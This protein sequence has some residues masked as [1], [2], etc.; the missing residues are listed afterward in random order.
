M[1]TV[2][3]IP[4]KDRY[5]ITSNRDEKMLR[6]PA[7]APQPY[8]INGNTLVYPKDADAGGT[9]IAMNENGNAAVLL[10]G[11]F[12]KHVSLSTYKLSRGLVFADIIS[13]AMPVRFF[14]H[15]ELVQIEPFTIIILEQNSL[16]ECRWDGSKKHCRQLP[17]YRSY[18]WSSVT[19][20]DD[21][22]I[23]KREQ[24]FAKWLNTH[25]H[26]TQEEILR[27][28]HF[29]GEGDSGNDICM[30]RDNKMLTVSI[31]GM[32]LGMDSGTIWYNDLKTDKRYKEKLVFANEIAAI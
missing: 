4:G 25:L 22:T 12:I 31:T 8:V 32:E 18:I 28:H 24:W 23:Q 19:L 10:N 1:C 17:K 27:F 20:Y 11:A 21:E 13:A 15:Q 7:I 29:A 3:F 9:W 5:F 16:Y 2:T 14:M 6:K 30:N 26:P